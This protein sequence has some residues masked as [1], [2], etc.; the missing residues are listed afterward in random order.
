MP[1]ARRHPAGT[2]SED[3]DMITVQDMEG[4]LFAGGDVVGDDGKK[5]GSLGQLFLDARTGNPAWVTVTTGLFGKAESF[6][7]MAGAELHGKELHVP[8]G[9]DLVKHAPR[10]ESAEGHLSPDEERDLYRHYGLLHDEPD[11]SL[12]SHDARQVDGPVERTDAHAAALTPTPTNAPAPV[13]PTSPGPPPRASY[14]EVRA[15]ADA[16][17][18]TAVGGATRDDDLTAGS[19]RD[20]APGTVHDGDTATTVVGGTGT[21]I[22]GATAASAGSPSPDT[23]HT[24]EGMVLQGEQARVVG[25]ERVPTERVRMRRY[26]VTEHKQVTVPVQR[27]EVRVEYEPV[28]DGALRGDPQETTNTR[29]EDQSAHGRHRADEDRA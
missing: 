22:G 8:Y 11:V 17:S 27:E 1:A 7:P 5:I 26:T 13:L 28:D 24:P 10:I 3:L 18:P 16:G 14:D 15:D 9:K 4:L 19:V 25:T 29:V 23:T 6:V 2:H 21:V 20:V 12:D